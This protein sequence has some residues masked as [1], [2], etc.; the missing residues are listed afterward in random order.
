MKANNFL[1]ILL[2]VTFS[3]M[4]SDTCFGN[5]NY[6]PRIK[7][8]NTYFNNNYDV[9]D[10]LSLWEQEDHW[11]TPEEFE[12]KGAGDCEDFAIAK[13]FKLVAQNVPKDLL[14]LSYVTLNG[15]QAHM[16]LLYHELA[17][18]TWFVLDNY[19][20]VILPVS[21]RFDMDFIYSF[22]ESG[23]W[24]PS[25]KVVGKKVGE[26]SSLSKWQDILSKV[27]TNK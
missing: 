16:V 17:D 23:V 5:V 15:N 8:V 21:K 6:W 10:D 11:A 9:T 26:A 18:D 2:I 7:A 12:A 20:P 3:M 14:V 1:K 24:L 4:L 22:N 19:N 25:Q 27:E 13:Y